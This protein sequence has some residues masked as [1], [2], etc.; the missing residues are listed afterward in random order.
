MELL[1]WRWSTAVQVSS[2]LMIALFFVVLA[3]SIR[4]AELRPWVGAWLANFGAMLVTILFWALQP[5]SPIVIALVR[6]LYIFLKTLFV[7]LMFAGAARFAGFKPMQALYRRAVIVIA[8]FALISMLAL[9]S[10]NQ[11]GMFQSAVI[12]IGLAA[13][14]ILLARTRPP[15]W[16]WLATALALRATFAIVEVFAYAVQD[17]D[18]SALM[19]TFLAAHS[20]FDTAAEW[21]IALGC[22]LML[23]HTIQLELTRMISDLHA[24]QSE[25]QTLL[26]HD[27]LTGLSNRRSLDA[28]LE[29]SRAEGAILLFFDINDFK[30]INDAYGHHVGDACLKRFSEALKANFRAEDRIVR[31]AGDEFV[32]VLPEMPAEEILRRLDHIR[33]D[34]QDASGDASPLRFSVGQSQLAAGGDADAA[35]RAADLAMYRRK[36]SRSA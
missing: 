5:Q 4:R 26:D 1:L 25:L 24:S 20:S 29:H 31:Y 8:A 13:C 3:Q 15:A 22:V 27:P 36:L 30:R 17:A 7:V 12:A 14:A 18:A 10:I 6:G 23:Y 35:L 2:T 34:L 33:K 9:D 21:M 16:A 19:R 32:A 28:I 11:L